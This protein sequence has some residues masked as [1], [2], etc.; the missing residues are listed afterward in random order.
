MSASMFIV[1]VAFRSNTRFFKSASASSFDANQSGTGWSVE[2]DQMSAAAAFVSKRDS[3]A[4]RASPESVTVQPAKQCAVPQRWCQTPM[5]KC[6]PEGPTASTSRTIK[7]GTAGMPS[8]NVAPVRFAPLR[9][10]LDRFAPFRFALDR[11]APFRFAPNRFTPDRF[12]PDRFTPD[13]SA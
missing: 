2:A 9:L 10:A 4:A 8:G 7:S 11:F 6:S 13:R 5:S 3:S 12:T 1:P